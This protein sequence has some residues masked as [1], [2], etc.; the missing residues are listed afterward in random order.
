MTTI[1]FPPASGLLDLRLAAITPIVAALP[2]ER[3]DDRLMGHDRKVL[4][5][6]IAGERILSGDGT[7]R[8]FRLLLDLLRQRLVDGAEAILDELAG[9]AFSRTE[10]AVEQT[11]VVVARC[12]ARVARK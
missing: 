7:P 10:V 9:L 3:L 1:R 6:A 8:D 12:G 4:L 2:D 5:R 11:R